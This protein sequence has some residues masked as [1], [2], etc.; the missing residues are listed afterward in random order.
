M[1]DRQEPGTDRLHGDWSEYGS[2]RWCEDCGEWVRLVEWQEHK[3]PLAKAAE[4]LTW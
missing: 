3:R 4:E 1:S 2:M